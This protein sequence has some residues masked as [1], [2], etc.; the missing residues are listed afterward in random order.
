M[1]SYRKTCLQVHDSIIYYCL[2]YGWVGG[3]P[4]KSSSPAACSSKVFLFAGWASSRRGPVAPLGASLAA[5]L[6]AAEPTLSFAIP[7]GMGGRLPPLPPRGLEAKCLRDIYY[8]GLR[9][10]LSQR[11]HWGGQGWGLGVGLSE[12]VRQKGPRE[13]APEAVTKAVAKACPLI[14]VRIAA[15]VHSFFSVPTNSGLRFSL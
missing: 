15:D 7:P 8:G 4:R 13:P 10:R 5:F 1:T 11:V 12:R 3:F 14:S 9:A 6:R 2:V